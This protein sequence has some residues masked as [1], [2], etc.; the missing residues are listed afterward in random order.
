MERRLHPRTQVQFE[1]RVTSQSRRDQ[2][3][4]GKLCD[5]SES[6]VSVV[7][8]FQFATADL[9]ELEVADSLLIG[10]V[11]Y[12][13]PENSLFRVGIE[14]QK[15]QLGNSDLSNLLQTTLLE[16]MPDV[17]GVEQEIQYR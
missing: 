4:I 1:A 8:P 10:R 12:S 7:L 6:G 11:I 5:L 15:V 14:V 16:S 9:V 17:P 13:N 2:F 3:F